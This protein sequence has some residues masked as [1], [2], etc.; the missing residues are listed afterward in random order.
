MIKLNGPLILSRHFCLSIAL[1]HKER[2]LCG[3]S[4]KLS[5]Y[6]EY[7]VS[8]LISWIV[9]FTDSFLRSFSL[10]YTLNKL[11]APG[12]TDE[13]ACIHGIR[14][15]ATLALL[16]AHKFLPVAVMPYTNRVKIT[17]VSLMSRRASYES[18]VVSSD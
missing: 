17:E 14:G 6:L 18:G 16:V 1:S 10:Y 8:A 12:T 3:T 15:I 4:L 9:F 5:R 11:T 2:V 13:I 7:F